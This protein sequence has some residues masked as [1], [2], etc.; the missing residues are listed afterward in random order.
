M[1]FCGTSYTGDIPSQELQA[2]SKSA[3]EKTVPV[4]PDTRSEAQLSGQMQDEI[5][6]QFTFLEQALGEEEAM[7]RFA[8]ILSNSEAI[9]PE[10]RKL[11]FINN[12]LRT[13]IE[14]L[15]N[16]QADIEKT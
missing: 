1:T 12:T 13:G 8:I 5:L 11:E 6:S 4:A 14:D 9:E 10:N 3:F 15:K 2:N 7:E 16:C